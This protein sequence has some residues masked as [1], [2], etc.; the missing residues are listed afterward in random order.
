[1]LFSPEQGMFLE[2]SSNKK[3]LIENSESA[4]GKVVFTLQN[5]ILVVHEKL[6]LIYI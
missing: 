5:E 2:K 3:D 1:M 6:T 4:S